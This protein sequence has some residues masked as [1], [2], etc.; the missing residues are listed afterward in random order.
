[1]FKCIMIILPILTIG[2]NNNLLVTKSKLNTL[3]LYVS[4]TMDDNSAINLEKTLLKL[5]R[6]NLNTLKLDQHESAKYLILI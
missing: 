1:M 4:K 3:K 5:Q 6:T 2:F